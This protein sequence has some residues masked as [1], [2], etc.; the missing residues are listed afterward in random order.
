ME[1]HRDELVVIVAGY[2]DQMKRFIGVNPGLASRFTRTLTF[3]DYTSDELVEIVAHQAAAHQ[4]LLPDATSAALAAFFE[5]AARGK[6]FGNG[7]FARQV[8]QDMTERHARRIADEVS[9]STVAITSEQLSI[10]VP[11]DLPD[12][13]TVTA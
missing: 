4:Y 13:D 1:D 5:R 2:P 7:R 12:L 6:G 8:F 11:D 3:D 10:L 9:D